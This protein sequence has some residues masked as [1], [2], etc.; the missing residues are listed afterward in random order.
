MLR[1]AAD[2]RTLGYLAATALLSVV[3]WKLG[4]VHPVLYPVTLFM[5]FTTAVISHNHN[6]LG[7]WRSKGLNLLTSYVIALF[8]GHPA[9]PWV[10]THNQGHPK[11]NHKPGARP[12]PPKPF[13]ANHL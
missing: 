13:P 5:F 9:V 6:H 10:P 8:Y 11:L 4:R 12:R 2:R 7:V 1:Y 3:N